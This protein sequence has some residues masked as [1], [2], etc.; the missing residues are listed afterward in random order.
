MGRVNLTPAVLAR[1]AGV[2]PATMTNL[3]R[4][5]DAHGKPT[6]PTPDLLKSVAWGLGTNGL[7]E[8]DLALADRAYVELMRAIGYL[9]APSL[10]YAPP[11]PQEVL[12]LLADNPDLTIELGHLSTGWK[13][14]DTK[15]L[16]ERIARFRAESV[17][18]QDEPHCQVQ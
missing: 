9:D 14:G 13:P 5:T 11:L 8:R 16:I 3:L 2:S 4:G 17:H 1:R 18:G 7:G 12:E 15:L 6:F 10:V